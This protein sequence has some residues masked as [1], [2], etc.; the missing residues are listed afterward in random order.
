M[1]IFRL[2]NMNQLHIGGQRCKGEPI[3]ASIH[4]LRRLWIQLGTKGWRL[5]AYSNLTMSYKIG[6]NVRLGKNL[7]IGD[8]VVIEDEVFLG[9]NV[10]LGDNALVRKGAVIG[11]NVIIGYRDANSD[12]DA[13]AEL[14]VTEIGEGV[15]LRSGIVVYWGTRIGSNSMIGHN[16]VIRENTIIGHDT[17]IGSLTAIE[18]DTKIGNCVGIH[19]QCHIT[20]FCDIG[21]YTFIA[22]LF[23]GANDRAMAHRRAGHGQNLVGFTTERYVRI[24]VGVTVLPGV[25]FGEGCIVG[26]GSVVT[27]DVPAYKVAIGTP[28][29]VVR[30]APKEEVVR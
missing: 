3:S 2:A 6:Q 28:A 8:N 29:R 16:T 27:K 20:K 4:E 11:S 15:K 7:E 1:I 24:A 21:D 30:D 23:V 22:P 12:E 10:S 17:Y 9:N 13:P 18:G 14:A 26:A 5:C 25:H 19:T